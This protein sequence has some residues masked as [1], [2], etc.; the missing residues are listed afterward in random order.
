M[1]ADD[2]A[3][4]RW[5]PARHNVWPILY[6]EPEDIPI[7]LDQLSGWMVSWVT[8]LSLSQTCDID[9]FRIALLAKFV[10]NSR[11]YAWKQTDGTCHCG[12]G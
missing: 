11:L 5:L 4:F 2:P 1:I 6:P 9:D 10:Q 8:H 12:V 7:L 3:E